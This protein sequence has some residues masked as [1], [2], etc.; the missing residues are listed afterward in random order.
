MKQNVDQVVMDKYNKAKPTLDLLQR[1]KQELNSLIP[2]SN[3][4]PDLSQN[5]CI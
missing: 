3:N 2:K 1:S 5:P 4:G